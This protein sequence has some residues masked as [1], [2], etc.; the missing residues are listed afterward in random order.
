MNIIKLKKNENK[1]E[2]GIYVF[3]YFTQLKTMYIL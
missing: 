2:Y 3:I 1:I